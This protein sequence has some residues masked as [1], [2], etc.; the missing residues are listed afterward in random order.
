[1]QAV[2]GAPQRTTP[3]AEVPPGRGY[4]R[5]GGG[6]VLRLQVPATPDPFDEEAP[7][8]ARAAVMA[9]LPVA[10]GGAQD[11][12]TA[13]PEPRTSL[14]PEPAAVAGVDRTDGPEG[15][16]VSDTVDTPV[17][18]QPEL[19]PEAVPEAVALRKEA[20]VRTVADLELG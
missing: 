18:R 11:G 3:A 15:T 7:Q 1:V 17:E 2:L 9:L 8:A 6:P 13:E 20:V 10:G 16:D 12:G 14:S 4:A 19:V 5:L